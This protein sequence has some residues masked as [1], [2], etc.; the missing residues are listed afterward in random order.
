MRKQ[1]GFTFVELLV[2]VA[3][4]GFSAFIALPWFTSVNQRYRYGFTLDSNDP[5]Q[6]YAV[7]RFMGVLASDC[8]TAR[9]RADQFSQTTVNVTLDAEDSE[10][11]LLEAQLFRRTLYRQADYLCSRSKE[12]RDNAI[13]NGFSA[14]DTPEN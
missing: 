7:A 4:V 12:V 2:Y 5:N 3:I 13:A 10:N 9:T 1:K 6:R 11:E 8:A 14:Y